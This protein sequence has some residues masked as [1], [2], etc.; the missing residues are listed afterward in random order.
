MVEGTRNAQLV[1][2]IGILQAETSSLKEEKNRHQVDNLAASY[3]SLVQTTVKISLGEGLVMHRYD[4][5]H[6][7]KGKVAYKLGP[8]I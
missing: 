6:Y 7:L 1:E 5:I 4:Q 3:D 8:Y 2:A